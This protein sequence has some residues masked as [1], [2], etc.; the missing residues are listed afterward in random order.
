MEQG[1]EGWL[2]IAAIV[3]VAAIGIHPSSRAAERYLARTAPVPA[4]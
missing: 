1:S 4:G 3:V 2:V